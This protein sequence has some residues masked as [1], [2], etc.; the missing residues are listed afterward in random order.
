MY[1]T[2]AEGDCVTCGNSG[3]VLHMPTD[4]EWLKEGWGAPDSRMWVVLSLLT[5]CILHTMYFNYAKLVTP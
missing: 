2:C 3:N 4:A 1:S 5:Q